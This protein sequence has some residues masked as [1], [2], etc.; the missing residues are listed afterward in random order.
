VEIHA[1]KTMLM[2][3]RF[4]RKHI[5][6]FE[7]S[8]LSKTASQVGVRCTRRLIG[9][10]V[11][12]EQDVRSG[13]PFADTIA[14]CPPFQGHVSEENPLRTIPYRALLPRRIENLL[15][16]GRCLSADVFANNQFSPIQFCI[17][18]GQAAGTAAALSARKNLSPRQID[19]VEL[20]ESLRAQGVPLPPSLQGRG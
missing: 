3:H 19:R 15:A 10:H 7:K 5:P 20:Q 13:I 2:T 6:G 18:M 1:R 9:E 4:F 8:Y 16:A 17:A 12:T 11:I 14:V